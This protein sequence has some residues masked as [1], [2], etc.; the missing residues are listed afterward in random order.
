MADKEERIFIFTQ[1]KACDICKKNLEE[2]DGLTPDCGNCSGKEFPSITRQ[3]AIEAIK[4]SLK[5]IQCWPNSFN[6]NIAVIALNAILK[7]AKK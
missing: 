4:K 6:D 3:E 1:Q 2:Y 5:K 7:G